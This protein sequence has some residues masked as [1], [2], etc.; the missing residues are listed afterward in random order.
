M[1]S[2]YWQR[3]R[4]IV[5]GKPLWKRCGFLKKM[6]TELFNITPNCSCKAYRQMLNI[7]S[8][9]INNRHKVGQAMCFTP[10]IQAC[11]GLRQD[12]K[13]EPVCTNTVRKLSQKKEINININTYTKC[14]LTEEYK[15]KCGIGTTEYSVIKRNS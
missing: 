14:P 3:C 1:K 9:S 13:L 4:E 12:D 10:I 6:N 2:K 7:R 11:G 5:N 15:S 8:S